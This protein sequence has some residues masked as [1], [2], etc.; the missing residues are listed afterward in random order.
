MLDQSQ[1]DQ[2]HRE[3]FLIARNVVPRDV[4]H[5]LQEEIELT[6]D[7]QARLLRDRGE[8]TEMHEG[9]DFLHRA[10][11]LHAQSP[12]I[13]DP[14]AHGTHTGPAIFDLLTCPA[15]ASKAARPGRGRYP[16]APGFGVFPFL[17]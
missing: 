1:I 8:I 5:A 12:S 10:A 16:V 17:C 4:V 13:L 2:Y 6:I 3:G 11:L 9:A 7:R 15:V 14:L